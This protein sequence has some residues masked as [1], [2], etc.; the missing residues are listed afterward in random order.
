MSKKKDLVSAAVEMAAEQELKP[1]KCKH[2]KG[3]G[4]TE[5]MFKGSVWEC[6]HC[7][8]TGYTGSTTSIAKWFREVLIKR[9][10]QLLEIRKQFN[11]IKQ[12]NEQL[13]SLLKDL[14][15]QWEDKLK[16]KLH[17]ECMEANRSR[18]D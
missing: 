14:E 4:E 16:V 17:A 1:D 7:D 15:P 10:N 18:F 12:E 3:K 9:T 2:C 6:F 11:L 8:G 13:K 5:G